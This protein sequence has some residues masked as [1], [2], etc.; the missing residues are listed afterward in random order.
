MPTGRRAALASPSITF[1]VISCPIRRVWMCGAFAP[2]RPMV[3]AETR[4]RPYLVLVESQPYF[5][6]PL[7]R[8]VS[9]ISRL[10]GAWKHSPRQKRSGVRTAERAGMDAERVHLCPFVQFPPPLPPARLYQHSSFSGPAA[11]KWR[12]HL[13]LGDLGTVRDIKDSF[14]TSSPFQNV[15]PHLQLNQRCLSSCR[16]I[17]CD[18]A[19]PPALRSDRMR[20]R[21][22]P[23]RQVPDSTNGRPEV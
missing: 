8:T 23:S 1:Q 17:L 4:S 15:T 3:A 12:A 9:S 18:I 11:W 2:A 16:G 19:L 7:L 22:R 6:L 20:R 5:M 21:R 14:Q 13:K 10:P